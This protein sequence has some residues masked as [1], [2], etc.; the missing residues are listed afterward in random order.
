MEKWLTNG[1]RQDSKD[2]VQRSRTESRSDDI[3]LDFQQH[4]ETLQD[5]SLDLFGK[6]EDLLAGRLTVVDKHQS[7]QPMNA[8]IPFPIAFP[9][10]ALD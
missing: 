2:W 10:C 1:C 3:R 9:A 5:V 4:A 8:H 6:L 7:L